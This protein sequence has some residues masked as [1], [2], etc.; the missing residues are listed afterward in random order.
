MLGITQSEMA[1]MLKVSRSHFSLYELGKRDL[2]AH[3][4][5][6]LAD[7]LTKLATQT[8]GQRN[9][10]ISG[11]L[12][13]TTVGGLLREN[14]YQRALLERKIGAME[15]K[16]DKVSK[17]AA[18]S[19]HFEAESTNRQESSPAQMR[20]FASQ[21]KSYASNDHETTLIKLYLKR[22]C[23]AAEREFLTSKL[24]K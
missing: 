12:Y 11:E 19:L 22:E 3:A 6:L 23:L 15:R 24:E 8:R 10:D 14:E 2:P 9:Q 7:L 5:V 4:K 21:F 18:L 13:Q 16:S 17:R 1:A 20:A